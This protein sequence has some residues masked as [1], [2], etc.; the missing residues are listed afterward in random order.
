MTSGNPLPAITSQE[1]E[2][3]EVTR[4]I[5][6]KERRSMLS[7]ED[8]PTRRIPSRVLK[9]VLAKHGRKDS[10]TPPPR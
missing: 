4:R 3:G 5:S 1:E 6:A 8:A 10:S 9:A 2:D 7:A